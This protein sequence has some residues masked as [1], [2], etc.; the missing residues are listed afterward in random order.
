MA[1]VW[2]FVINPAAP[3][4]W[5]YGWDVGR[6]ET[7]LRSTDKVW[8]TANYFRKIRPGDDLAVYVKNAG[9]P[10]GIYVVGT[11]TAV[12]VVARDFTWQP[13]RRRS[14]ALLR[15]PVP[16]D[17]VYELFGR[18]YGGALRRIRPDQERE[19]RRLIA[20]VTRAKD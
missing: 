11:V 2:L 10:D 6:P 16:R 3:R 12:D 9:V 19:W 8:P 20:A 17:L 18:G 7:L 1:A 4:D 5:D 15:T 13:D 14:A